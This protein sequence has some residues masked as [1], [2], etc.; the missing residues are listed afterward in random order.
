MSVATDDNLINVQAKSIKWKVGIFF[1]ILIPV[2][3]IGFVFVGVFDFAYILGPLI[4]GLLL[5]LLFGPALLTVNAQVSI[6]YDPM[7]K[8]L[9]I[10]ELRNPIKRLFC[11][12][13]EISTKLNIINIQTCLI[14]GDCGNYSF[15]VIQNSGTTYAVDEIF[16]RSDLNAIVEAVNAVI[17]Q[18][19]HDVAVLRAA[20]VR[21]QRILVFVNN[22]QYPTYNTR[23]NA[24]YL[25][26][27]GRSNYNPPSQLP[28]QQSNHGVAQT[29]PI[30]SSYPAVIQSDYQDVDKE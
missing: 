23:N 16:N 1:T 29:A 5:G 6:T 12:D 24:G 8:T 4:I 11:M 9:T 7:N 10:V 17:N 21:P 15:V 13:K 3:I 26:Q 27:V 18:K 25:Q 20:N 28:Y 30:Q 14:H 2:A 22:D 19:A